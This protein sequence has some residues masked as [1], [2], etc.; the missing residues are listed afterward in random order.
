MLSEDIL[1]TK[2]VLGVSRLGLPIYLL[3]I[4]ANG[5]SGPFKKRKRKVIFI[6]AR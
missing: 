2:K 3:K 6:I 4:T 1:F 5:R